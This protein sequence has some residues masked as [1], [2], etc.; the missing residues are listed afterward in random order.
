MFS[1][2]CLLLGLH[3]YLIHFA[4][5]AFIPHCQICNRKVP[6]L[7]VS[8]FK[9]NVFYH[10]LK[11]TPCVLQSLAVKYLLHFLHLRCEISQW[12]FTA[13]YECFRPNN[14]GC[15][16]DCRDYRGGW[17]RSCPVLIRQPFYSWQKF[18]KKKNTLARFVT[19][20]CIAKD[21]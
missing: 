21:T 17:H 11:H 1:V 9:I 7:F 10:Y 15:D 18:F 5:L 19:L 4:P 20:S 16:L 6:S 2:Q 8:L 12:T 3:G 13:S 14:C